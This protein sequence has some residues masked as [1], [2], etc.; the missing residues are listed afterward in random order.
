VKVLSVKNPWAY[1]LIFGSWAG[2]KDVENR[3]KKTNYRGPLLIHASKNPAIEYLQISGM[4]FM[5]DDSKIHLD[6]KIHLGISE[7]SWA[8]GG[9]NENCRYFSLHEL[10]E[11]ERTKGL[12]I[13]MVEL[14]DCVENSE[15]KWAETG[16]YHWI[17]KNPRPLV[18]PI[19]ARGSLGLWE[20]TGE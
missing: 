20:Y 11:F 18:K 3:S 19:P 1:F 16:L 4:V 17:M 8:T 13:G 9:M 6:G 7:S 15:S 14:V 10:N 2:I 5:K 12:I